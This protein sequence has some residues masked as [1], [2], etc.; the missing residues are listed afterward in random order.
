MGDARG[1]GGEKRVAKMSSFSSPFAVVVAGNG[2][3]GVRFNLKGVGAV[4][5]SIAVDS[6][7]RVVN[8]VRFGIR[9]SQVMSRPV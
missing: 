5:P 1:V 3:K 7:A 2:I 9:Y 8:V 4:E 6:D